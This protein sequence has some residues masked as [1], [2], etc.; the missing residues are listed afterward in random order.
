VRVEDV[1]VLEAHAP[2][3]LIAARDEILPGA[4]I[5]VRSRPHPVASLAG[6]DQL[7]AWHLAD[8][9]AAYPLGV[10]WRL[11]VV[12]GEVEVRHPEIKG[13]DQDGPSDLLAPIPAQGLPCTQR[14]SWQPQA[15]PTAVPVQ[16]AL[17]PVRGEGG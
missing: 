2:E 5:A 13:P 9:L 7:V 15:T 17:V 6:D 14:D 4:A 8:D 11:A 3:R 1:E 10:A 16:H 12:V